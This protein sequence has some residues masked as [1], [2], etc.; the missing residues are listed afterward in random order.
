MANR[1][2]SRAGIM[3][4]LFGQPL[5]V[6][7]ETAAQVLG[8]I[9]P[10][11]NVDQL[12]L[13]D[14]AQ[15]LGIDDLKALASA[16]VA[17][18]DAASGI[19]MQAGNLPAE[20]I[21]LVQ[22]GV[23]HVQLRGE[24]VAENHGSIQPSS[25]FTGYD[26]IRA[27]VQAADND[28]MVRGIV[29]DV[30]SPGGE[31]ADL[32]ELTGFLMAR[33]G[34][35]PMRAVIRNCGAS[36][37]YS[38]AC[39]ADE[40]TLQ[41]LGVAGSNGVITMHADYS[42]ALANDGVAVTLI[43]SG[44]HKADG[45]PFEPLPENVR[46]RIQTMVD[47]TAAQLFAHVAAAR[48]MTAD[49]VR[50]QQ[51]QIYLGEE[52]VAAGLADKIMGWQDSIA[53]FEAAVNAPAPSRR[54]GTAP[55]G[56]RSAKGTSMSTTQTA[57][58]AEQQPEFTQADLDA[59][60]SAA[61]AQGHTEGLTSGA[62]AERARI[63]ALAELDAGST[64]SASLTAAIEAG[65]SAGDFAIGLA[66]AAKAEGANALAA[67]AAEAT[68]AAALPAGGATVV[69]AAAAGEPVNRGAAYAGKKAAAKPA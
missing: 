23:A 60:A 42:Q 27:Q 17:R 59:A 14:R 19:E 50:A 7:P 16:E 66:K 20:R 32:F 34:T 4:R 57:P 38:V 62:S 1:S 37:A 3:A 24:M 6:M 9:G 58:A 30:D 39:C 53:E 33:R 52:A 2:Y 44:A 63:S 10:R 41:P 48:G 11:L 69:A 36:A 55:S 26:G 40:V 15:L 35:K 25:G 68:P 12:F 54:G 49:Q 56:A 18:I 64:V 67:A 22:N 46:A 13:T 47:T 43:T 45:N 65:T 61:H 8:A 21:M 29:L 5:A 28:P 51:A 31:C